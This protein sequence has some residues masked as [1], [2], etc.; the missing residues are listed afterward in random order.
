MVLLGLSIVIVLLLL[1]TFDALFF[2][3]IIVYILTRYLLL[4]LLPSDPT[5]QTLSF[6]LPHLDAAAS[7]LGTLLLV[8]LI[9]LFV[10]MIYQ[11]FI[12]R[13]NWTPFKGDWALVT[14]A[15]AGIGR[16]FAHGL[17]SRGLNVILMSRTQADLQRVAEEIETKYKVKTMVFPFNFLDDLSSYESIQKALAPLQVSVLV[18]NVGGPASTEHMTHFLA[19]MPIQP[20]LNTM[21]LNIQPMMIL[22]SMLIPMMM[23]LKRGAIINISSMCKEPFAAPLFHSYCGSKSFVDAYTRAMC[24]E[25]RSHNII[26]QCCVPGPVISRSHANSGMT[27]NFFIPDASP[28]AEASLRMHGCADQIYPKLLHYL[29]EL[30][31]SFTNSLRSRMKLVMGGEKNLEK[32]L[33]PAP[34]DEKS[35]DSTAKPKKE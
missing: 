27:S 32:M 25:M 1:R 22:T 35:T 16:A 26:V 7:F 14:G 4:A 9:Y 3:M 29:L 8:Y 6:T 33:H 17:A 5:F 20:A 23:K 30:K 11:R 15:S 10:R 2:P 34:K 18:N 31:L 13:F 28:F 19:D 12:Y 21:K 24:D